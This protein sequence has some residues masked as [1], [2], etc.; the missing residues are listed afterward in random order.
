MSRAYSRSPM[1][2]IQ[3]RLPWVSSATDRS[4]DLN[5]NDPKSKQC[6]SRYQM[7]KRRVHQQQQQQQPSSH[8]TFAFVENSTAAS[9]SLDP[10]QHRLVAGHIDKPLPELPSGSSSIPIAPPQPEPTLKSVRDQKSRS[11]TDPTSPYH[12]ARA[13]V[14]R[15][16]MQ[17]E[18]QWQPDADQ[19]SPQ[20]PEITLVPYSPPPG[21]QPQIFARYDSPRTSLV[22]NPGSGPPGLDER[23]VALKSSGSGNDDNSNS[24]SNVS[25]FNPF[26]PTDSFTSDLREIGL[27]PRPH[28]PLGNELGWS[29][30]LYNG[31]RNNSRNGGSGG[32]VLESD[33]RSTENFW[34]T[35]HALLLSRRNHGA[36]SSYMVDALVSDSNEY[37]VNYMLADNDFG[38]STPSVRLSTTQKVSRKVDSWMLDYITSLSDAA[39]PSVGGGGRSVRSSINPTAM[40]SSASSRSGDPYSQPQNP[41][42]GRGRPN[43]GYQNSPLC[44]QMVLDDLEP[45]KTLEQIDHHGHE[46]MPGSAKDAA[47]PD[48]QLKRL[49]QVYERSPILDSGG[50]APYSSVAKTGPAMPESHGD[51]ADEPEPLM[52][53]QSTTFVDEKYTSGDQKK[54]PQHPIF[55]S[56]AS[57]LPT[58]R[59]SCCGIRLRRSLSAR[60]LRDRIR[61]ICFP[62]SGGSE[63]DSYV[64]D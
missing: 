5:P 35:M 14:P 2:V 47:T 55:D 22:V 11:P 53:R 31:D 40:A 26:T 18:R 60:H 33:D 20:L 58:I 10:A 41:A 24:N 34:K 36:R 21:S 7:H 44:R 15:V 6:L 62:R 4:Q 28:L 50:P 56:T 45:L 43:A 37:L 13:M 39:T 12:G 64:S 61:T 32:H 63:S 19:L 16:Q 46:H 52:R 23:N 17:A 57:D 3:P 25:H 59:A 42:A 9:T 1:Q 48:R 8:P 38:C 30:S 49:G 54:P 27:V 51:Q 29:P